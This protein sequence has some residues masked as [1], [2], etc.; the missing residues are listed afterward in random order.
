MDGTFYWDEFEYDRMPLI[1]CTVATR[2]F[3]V[4]AN[5][6]LTHVPNKASIY[7]FEQIDVFPIRQ[8]IP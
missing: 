2:A 4:A 1:P 3:V 8:V 6:H 5:D 7:V